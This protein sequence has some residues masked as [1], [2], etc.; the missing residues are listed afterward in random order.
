MELKQQQQEADVQNFFIKEKN[1]FLVGRVGNLGKGMF[2][3]MIKK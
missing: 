1:V 3:Q 2:D